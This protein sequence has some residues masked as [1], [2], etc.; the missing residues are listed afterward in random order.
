MSATMKVKIEAIDGL[1]DI[2]KDVS[3]AASKTSQDVTKSFNK[4]NKSIKL[5]TATAKGAATAI[6]GIAVAA[7]AVVAGVGLASAAILKASNTTADYADEVDKTS[8]RIGLSKTV[9]QEFMFVTKQLGLTITSLERGLAKFQKTTGDAADGSKKAQ[10]SFKR[11]NI[12]YQNA[13]GSLRTMDELFPEVIKGLSEMQDETRRNQTAMI[14]FGRAG[15]DLVPMLNS[16]TESIEAL[17][18]KAHELNIVMDDEGVMSAVEYKDEMEALQMQFEGIFREISTNFIPILKDNI[19]PL[20]RTRIIPLFKDLGDAIG[21][22]STFISPILTIIDKL[23]TKIINFVN[24][25]IKPTELFG[26]I[27]N[28]VLIFIA[29]VLNKIVQFFAK[30][31]GSILDILDMLVPLLIDTWVLIFKT[32]A[33]VTAIGLATIKVL[34]KYFGKDIFDIISN[35]FNR[36]F[37]VMKPIISAFTKLMDGDFEGF[38]TD[39]LLAWN[40]LWDGIELPKLLG[41]VKKET[42]EWW[43][44]LV[45]IWSDPNNNIFGKIGDSFKI[46]GDLVLD[47]G[48]IMFEWMG[49]NYKTIASVIL[50]AGLIGKLILKIASLTGLKA[51]WL[52]AVAGAKWAV[53]TIASLIGLKAAWIAATA[54]AGAWA[55]IKLAKMTGVDKAW[56]NAMGDGFTIKIA[57][58]TG[59]VAGALGGSVVG[60]LIAGIVSK[61]VQSLSGSNILDQF[62]RI[63]V[64]PNLLGEQWSNATNWDKSKMILSEGLGWLK[65]GVKSISLKIKDVATGSFGWI[66]T[67]AMS[68]IIKTVVGLKAAV[69]SAI[70]AVAGFA[71]TSATLGGVLS[72]FVLPMTIAVVGGYIAAKVFDQFKTQIRQFFGTIPNNEEIFYSD[73]LSPNYKPN[74]QPDTNLSQSPEKSPWQNFLGWLAKTTGNEYSNGTILSG[75]GGGDIIPALLEPGEAVVPKEIV[76]GGILSITEWFKSLGTGV[77]KYKKGTPGDYKSENSSTKQLDNWL[78]DQ[79]NKDAAVELLLNSNI[80]SGETSKVIPMEV[81]LNVKANF[82]NKDELNEHINQLESESGFFDLISKIYSEINTEQSKMYDSFKNIID[83]LADSAKIG[84]NNLSDEA[85]QLFKEFENL[86]EITPELLM[87]FLNS[88]IEVEEELENVNKEIENTSEEVENTVGN[89]LELNNRP[90]SFFDSIKKGIL[91]SIPLLRFMKDEWNIMVDTFAKLNEEESFDLSNLSNIGKNIKDKVIEITPDIIINMGSKIKDM[92]V[93][94]KNSISNFLGNDLM[95][96]LGPIGIFIGQMMNNSSQFGEII[97]KLQPVIQAVVDIFGALLEPIIPIVNVLTWLTPIFESIG[98]LLQTMIE[99]VFRALFPVIKTVT[100]IFNRLIRVLLTVRSGFLQIILSLAKAI[101]KIPFVNAKNAINSLSRKIAESN[102]S[103]NDLDG[104]YNELKEMTYDTTKAKEE[105]NKAIKDVTEELLNV[106]TGYKLALNRFNSMTGRSVDSTEDSEQYNYS[107]SKNPNINNSNNKLND[108][109]NKLLK[110]IISLLKANSGNVTINNVEINGSNDPA[111]IWRKL[112][113]VIKNERFNNT[114]T[115]VEVGPKY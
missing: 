73:T 108:D 63:S 49:K 72:G 45:G 70:A 6:K 55:A 95:T 37:N 13:D 69:N 50:A 57:G 3:K 8:Q 36:I 54:G 86:E 60:G 56:D 100:M 113:E 23:S 20:I 103:I 112:K 12:E 65:S 43:N 25:T 115:I 30:H 7:T 5:M 97:G 93:G 66:K 109:S 83:P 105:E 24:K 71:G 35:T 110:Q 9:T 79:P 10:D 67:G 64:L 96:A 44:E 38:K 106:P 42:D 16:G 80:L 82:E 15:R 111:E 81:Q 17:R 47:I 14:L 114:G 77:K 40:N 85:R 92:F 26:K 61:A 99:P 32:L 46:T 34:W 18:K 91:S 39:M 87:D 74:Y 104:S 4:S 51:A 62:G 31:G 52:A 53:L 75:Y 94:V 76:R 68:L 89:N 27:W 1:S 19:I 84:W 78:L 2:L 98:L 59:A 11:L 107:G 58:I 88:L 29:N 21:S 28:N 102:N 90:T 41:D 22:I 48:N 33:R 101:D